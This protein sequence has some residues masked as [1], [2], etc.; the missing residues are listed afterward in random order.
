[1]NL[2]VIVLG[3]E[4]H[5]GKLLKPNPETHGMG[6]STMQGDY[7]NAEDNCCQDIPEG[8]G[9]SW[10]I[11]TMNDGN[12]VCADMRDGDIEDQVDCKTTL[13][14]MV[15]NDTRLTKTLQV[16]NNTLHYGVYSTDELDD[17]DSMY[18]DYGSPLNYDD[19]TQERP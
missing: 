2:V 18:Y 17:F 16:L 14:T 15:E 6:A 19:F 8:W 13:D 3:Y 5:P 9:Q 12:Y 10:C 7:L 11:E 4:C 1:M